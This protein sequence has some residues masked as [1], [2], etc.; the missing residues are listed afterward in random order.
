MILTQLPVDG[1]VLPLC[2]LRDGNEPGSGF[3]DALMRSTRRA[4]RMVGKQEA[5]QKQ[6]LWEI[7]QPSSSQVLT[8][9]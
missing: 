7:L 9:T 8:K 5:V 1:S 6:G 3:D 2:A 4:G